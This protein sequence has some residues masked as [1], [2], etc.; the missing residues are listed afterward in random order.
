MDG[1][2][3]Y[4]VM[5]GWLLWIS[6]QYLSFLD[7]DSFIIAQPFRDIVLVFIDTPIQSSLNST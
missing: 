4:K 3:S 2:H 6:F 5:I 1:G 7:Y